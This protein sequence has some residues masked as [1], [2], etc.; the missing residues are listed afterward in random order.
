MAVLSLLVGVFFMLPSM[1]RNNDND[2]FLLVREEPVDS[3]V[4]TGD[5]TLPRARRPSPPRR[6][7]P[8]RIELNSADS[9]TLVKVRGIGPYYASRILRYREQLGG[10]YSVNQLKD[11]KLTYLSV[12]TLLPL[13]TVDAGRVRKK[14]MDT[15]SFRSLL[16]HPYLEYEDVVL[17][18]NAKRA[19]GDTLYFSLLEEKGVLVPQKLKKIKPYF[20]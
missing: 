9:V 11:L 4:I 14:A 3:T 20:L 2:V 7:A 15:M 12:D 8:A 13:F 10:F 6:A 17:I 16:R 1:L 5:D 19:A 18:F